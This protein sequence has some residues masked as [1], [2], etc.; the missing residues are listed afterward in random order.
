MEHNLLVKILFAGLRAGKEMQITVSGVSMNPTLFE[1][2]RVTVQ[3]SESYALGD[4]LVF[5]YKGEL[6]IHRLLKTEGDRF[7][8]KGD[9]AFRIE[10][11][12]QEAIAGKVVQVG[13]APLP[14][15]PPPLISL[16]YQIGRNFRKNGFRADKTK[17]SGIYRFY[18]QILWKDETQ[19]MEYKKNPKMDYIPADDTSLAVFDPESGDTHFFDETGIDILNCLDEPCDLE[20]LLARLCEIYNATPDDIRADVLEFLADCIAKKVIEVL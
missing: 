11:F 7:F 4:V 15:F 19:T 6:L 10:D 8:C 2:D 13:N 18:H 17:E 9:H 12:T 20:R 14:P 5:L 3:R 1:G 16:S